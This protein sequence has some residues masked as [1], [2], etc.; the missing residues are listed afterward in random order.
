M[1]IETA[2]FFLLIVLLKFV[3]SR[4]NFENYYKDLPLRLLNSNCNRAILVYVTFGREESFFGLQA[5]REILKAALQIKA[6][7][8][9]SD[10]DKNH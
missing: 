7:S 4:A 2:Q 6:I 10:C 1:G 8:I 9:N 5:L 3:I